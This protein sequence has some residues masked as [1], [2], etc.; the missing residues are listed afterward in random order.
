MLFALTDAYVPQ[1]RGLSRGFAHVGQPVVHPFGHG[2]WF[3]VAELSDALE[4][5][6]F[7]VEP[8]LRLRLGSSERGHTAAFS[9]CGVGRKLAERLDASVLR[10]EAARAL[11]ASSFGCRVQ[12]FRQLAYD[13]SGGFGGEH[14]RR[15]LVG[16]VDECER[17]SWHVVRFVHVLWLCAYDCT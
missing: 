16:G 1:V 3:D 9:G 12:P 14:D 5:R 7:S 17:V 4:F 2:G 8:E 10:G 13:G 6:E 11:H 15:G